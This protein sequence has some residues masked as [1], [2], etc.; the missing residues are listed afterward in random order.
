MKGDLQS[1]Y[2]LRRG[3]ASEVVTDK[4]GRTPSDL[5]CEGFDTGFGTDTVVSPLRDFINESVALGV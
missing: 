4:L 2:I 3:G 1:V 5:R